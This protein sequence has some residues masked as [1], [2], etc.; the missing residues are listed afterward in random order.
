MDD[1]YKVN[2]LIEKA[3]E[4]IFKDI[5]ECIQEG[6]VYNDCI[7]V[8]Y[9]YALG[10]IVYSVPID[11]TYRDMI[12]MFGIRPECA[13]VIL[14]SLYD[15]GCNNECISIPGTIKFCSVL[16]KIYKTLCNVNGKETEPFSI[17]SSIASEALKDGTYENVTDE[18][19]LN[20]HYID[21]LFSNITKQLKYYD[22]KLD[23]DLE[24]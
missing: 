2:R 8:N 21:W 3:Y 9:D 10:C 20:F 23:T 11:S 14:Q 15:I 4:V 6:F 7:M 5:G 17:A 18:S 22:H 1:I 12:P 19:P 24:Y 13:M 16:Q